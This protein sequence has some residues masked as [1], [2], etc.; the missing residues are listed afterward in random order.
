MSNSEF[1]TDANIDRR[2]EKCTFSYIAWP[3]KAN[4]R[5]RNVTS[6]TLSSGKR[7]GR[8]EAYGGMI[9]HDHVNGWQAIA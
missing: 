6:V 2:N 4:N 8:G 1:P 5:Q 3:N 7:R 9:A